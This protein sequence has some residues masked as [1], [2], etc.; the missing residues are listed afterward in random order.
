M[1]T[2]DNDIPPFVEQVVQ[3]DRVGADLDGED[4]TVEGETG[5]GETGHE[6]P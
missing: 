6:W 2:E 5:H 3:N 1:H 4:D